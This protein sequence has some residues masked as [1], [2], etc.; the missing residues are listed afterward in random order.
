MWTS[1]R[2]S[3]PRVCIRV[4]TPRKFLDILTEA[5]AYR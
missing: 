4:V 5:G 2:S 1:A 3:G